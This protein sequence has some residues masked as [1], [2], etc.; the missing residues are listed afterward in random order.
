[1]GKTEGV[2]LKDKQPEGF[3]KLSMKFANNMSVKMN[4]SS[5]ANGEKVNCDR[6]EPAAHE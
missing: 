6:S 2:P 4:Y 1:M 3:Q 5:L